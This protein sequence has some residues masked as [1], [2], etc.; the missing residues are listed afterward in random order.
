MQTKLVEVFQ[1]GAEKGGVLDLPEDAWPA[2]G[3][4]IACQRAK[5]DSDPLNS[6]VFQVIGEEGHLN[7]ASIPED[8]QP[9]DILTVSTP[10]GRGFVLP[11]DLQHVALLPYRVSP[12]R[13]LCLMRE[14]LNMGAAV[15][16]FSDTVPPVEIMNRLPAAVEVSPISSLLENLDWPDFLAVDL[17]RGDL[18][19]FSTL[20]EQVDL[21]LK[22]QVLVRTAMPCRGVGE[23]GVCAVRTT[24]GWQL[25]CAD[26]PVFPLKDVLHVAQ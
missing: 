2:P 26:G 21:K 25:A 6:Q 22:G 12:G 11:P 13:I 8:W 1:I 23:C 20:F 14:A 17:E 4:H 3:Q 7:V 15:S 9:G 19:T 10:Q 24:K 5:G 16:F 18:P